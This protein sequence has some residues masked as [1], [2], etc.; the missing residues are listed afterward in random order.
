MTF[1]PFPRSV[2]FGN[3]GSEKAKDAAGECPPP[4]SNP[5]NRLNT[6]SVEKTRQDCQDSSR[7][8][9]SR[10]PI[11]SANKRRLER[12]NQS[13]RPVRQN[14]RCP[15]NPSVLLRRGRE[16][17]PRIA[18]LQTATLPL[19]Y[20]ADGA[21]HQGN[22]CL[23]SVNATWRAAPLGVMEWWSNGVMGWWSNGVMEFQGTAV[24]KPPLL[25][26][27][28]FSALSTSTVRDPFGYRS[29]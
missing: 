1:F 22:G 10:I 21:S 27:N 25:G 2:D 9:D 11:S 17:N 15:Q 12:S 16:S 20:P 24:S 8:L 28:G 3:A 29:G 18:V 7:N 13:S 6:S 26:T 4:D 23:H 14:P 5:S 19:G